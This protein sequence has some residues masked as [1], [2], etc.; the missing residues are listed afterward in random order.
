MLAGPTT[1]QGNNCGKR[2]TASHPRHGTG[3][4]DLEPAPLTQDVRLKVTIFSMWR[5]CGN[6]STGWTSVTV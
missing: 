2:K 1:S 4:A 6:K 5:V 3:A